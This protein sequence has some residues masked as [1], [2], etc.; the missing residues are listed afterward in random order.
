MEHKFFTVV[1]AGMV[2]S[3]QPYEIVTVLYVLIMIISRLTLG[4]QGKSLFQAEL[5]R[6][7]VFERVVYLFYLV[8]FYYL[9]CRVPGKWGLQGKATSPGP[10]TNVRAKNVSL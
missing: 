3:M 2:I 5:F 1:L 10:Q 9:Y 8:L 6:K 4:Y 7:K